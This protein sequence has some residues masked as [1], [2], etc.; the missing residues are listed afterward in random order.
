MRRSNGQ[1]LF[2]NLQESASKN[3]NKFKQFADFCHTFDLTNLINVTAFF[4]S[5]MSQSSLDVILTN[6]P[7]SFQ[8]TTL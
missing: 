3:C 2:D 1:N 4:K 7:R 8:K 6:R 5:A